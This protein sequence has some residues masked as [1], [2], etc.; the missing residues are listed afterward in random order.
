M[1][2]RRDDAELVRARLQQLRAGAL[3]QPDEP[4]APWAED[5]PDAPAAPDTA[6]LPAE[7]WRFNPG[8]RGFAAIAL[9]GAVAAGLA[10]AGFIRARPHAVAEP[11]V[12]HQVTPS[13]RVSA[14]ASPLGL[15]VD[16]V[17]KV[18]HPGLVTLPAGSRVADAIRAA[19]GLVPGAQTGLLNLA[20]KLAD[21]EQVAVGVASTAS[22]GSADISSG[23]LDLNSATADQLDTLPGVGPV[24]AQRIIDWRTAHGGFSSIDELRQVS[25]IGDAKFAQL[26]AH[27]TV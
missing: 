19:G 10:V 9:L 15:V 2:V 16:V 23:L 18:R 21:G 1:P 12:P 27:V 17:G 24:L 6:D 14:S 4:A 13:A 3:G 26:H 20:R 11:L 8:S 5:A 25:G 7:R 22:T